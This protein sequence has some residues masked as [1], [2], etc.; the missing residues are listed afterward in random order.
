MQSNKHKQGIQKKE[1]SLVVQLVAKYL[2]YWPL[3]VIFLLLSLGVA[4]IKL[5][6]TIPLY[7]AYATIIIKDEKKGYDDSKLMESLDLINTKKIIENEI[8]VLQS[9]TLMNAVVKKLHLYAPVTQVGKVKSLSAYT[10]SPLIIETLNPDSL[11]AFD[12]IDFEYN[13]KNGTVLLNKSYKTA[14]N[15]WSNTPYGKLRFIHNAKYASIS[16]STRPYYFSLLPTGYVSGGI[17]A[18]LTVSPSSKLSSVIDL[19]YKDEIPKRAEDILNELI[20]SYGEAALGEKNNLAKNTLSFIEERLNIV[21]K[22]LDSI[23]AKLQHYKAGSG[24]VDISR[25]GQLYLENASTNDKRLGE[26]NMQIAAVDQLEKYATTPGNAG[27]LP[28]TLGINDPTLSQQMNNLNSLQLKYD[29]LKGTVPENNPVMLA[30]TSQISQVKPTILSNI[31]SQRKNLEQSR[32]SLF[33]AGGTYN[34]MISSIPQKERQLVEITRDQNIKNGIYSFLLQKREE[35]E[36]S[37][38]STLSDSRVVN[39]AQASNSPVSPKRPMFYLAAI[40][41]AFIVPIGFITAREIFS[42]K[43]LYRQ[44]IESLTNISII[45]EIGF[46]KSKDAPVIEAG[47]RT[48]L[49]EEFRKIRVSLSYL[50]IDAT[51]KKIVVTSSISGE[52]KSFIAANLARSIS[53]TGKKVMLVDMDLHNPGLGKFFGIKEQP[54]VSEYLTGKTKLPQIIYRIPDNDNL[55]YISSGALQKDSSELLENGKVQNLITQLDADFDVVIIDAAPIVLITD[56][57]L[58]SS[59]CDAT[60]YIVRHQFTPKALVK[61]IDEGIAINPIKNPAIIFNGVKTRGFFKNN[62]GYGYNNYIYG[63]DNTKKKKFFG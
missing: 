45:G 39:Y 59:L 14:I 20:I 44:E 42:P 48:Q 13:A 56:A 32:S 33:S 55:Y 11:Q 19:S 46:N 31:Q 18:N 60:L 5:R 23:E 49:A 50:G 38:A 21:S 37:Y 12:R 9:R 52:G 29:Q 6:Y 8:E 1:D 22:D 17:L 25:Q 35:S 54:G 36:L 27:V 30:L 62:Y 58:L 16:D 53:L 28:S 47:K 26:L 61:R 57:Y 63:Y 40:A 51:H 24:A 2:P 7:E 4:Y 10:M 34:S 3:F 41:F 43:I 15:Q